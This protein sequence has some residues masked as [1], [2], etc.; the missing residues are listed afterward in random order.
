LLIV[1]PPQIPQILV[2]RYLGW[3]AG[4]E[5][6]LGI[7]TT[8]IPTT[9]QVNSTHSMVSKDDDAVPIEAYLQPQ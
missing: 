9:Q 2:Y 3:D 6:R 1:W 8:I 4:L 5:C 7:K